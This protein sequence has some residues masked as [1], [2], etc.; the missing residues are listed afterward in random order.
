MSFSL[1]SAFRHSCL[2]LLL[3]CLLCPSASE[4]QVLA[5]RLFLLD[6][7]RRSQVVSKAV[8]DE[9]GDPGEVNVYD[10]E[11]DAVADIQQA[12]SVARRDGRR[13][14]LEVGGAWCIWCKTLDR[15]FADNLDL[16]ALRKSNYV[17]VKVNFS[18]ENENA[19]ALKRYP[20]PSVYPHL[21]VLDQQGKLVASQD[22]VELEEGR[23]YHHGRMRNFLTR[24]APRQSL[25]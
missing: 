4:A 10:S 6:E 15:Y 12:L 1:A 17:M 7:A 25:R 13:V 20:K 8:A 16:L 19:A 24:N 21:Y 3:L 23:S 18:K 22:T 11:R 14:V 5:T 2:S 9:T